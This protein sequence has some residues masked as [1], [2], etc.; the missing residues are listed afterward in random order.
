M[1]WNS[2]HHIVQWLIPVTSIGGAWVRK[3]WEGSSW[4]LTNICR[5]SV[6]RTGQ[7]LFR[8]AQWQDRGHWTPAGRPLLWGWG[9]TGTGC[10]VRLCVPFLSD[11][12]NPPGCFPVPLAVGNCCWSL[13]L[14]SPEVPFN[15]YSS[16]ITSIIHLFDPKRSFKSCC[17][18]IFGFCTA[19]V[20]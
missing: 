18:S 5:L 20:Q 14:W 12:Q 2:R 10:P 9:N 16:V 15:P 3:A 13:D 8:G 7:A 17:E 11:T 4:M 6:K 19:V 1:L